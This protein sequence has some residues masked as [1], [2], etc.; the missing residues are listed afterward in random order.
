M[1]RQLF[2]GYAKKEQT[3]E[4]VG[5]AVRRRQDD[6]PENGVYLLIVLCG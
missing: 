3:E 2:F 6:A 4:G 5:E 1:N